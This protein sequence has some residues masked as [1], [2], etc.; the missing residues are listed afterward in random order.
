M[1][2]SQGWLYMDE[3]IIIL[4]T[5]APAKKQPEFKNIC[6]KVLHFVIQNAC[7]ESYF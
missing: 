5:P 7:H 3:T 4:K 2:G 1:A 6:P